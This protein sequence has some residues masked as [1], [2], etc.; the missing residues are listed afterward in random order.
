MSVVR[1]SGT[2]R[3]CSPFLDTKQVPTKEG[4]RFLNETSP[5]FANFWKNC[6]RVFREARGVGSTHGV[7]AVMSSGSCWQ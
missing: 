4:A 7:M 2:M 5:N 1:G 6:N 3:M